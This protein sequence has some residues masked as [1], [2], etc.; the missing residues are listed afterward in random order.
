MFDPNVHEA[1]FAV[2]VSGENKP[3]TIAVIQKVGYSLHERTL[4]PAY[5]G[6]YTVWEDWILIVQPVE[7][8]NLYINKPSFCHSMKVW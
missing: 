6:V 3:N 8:D 4:R 5:V 2:P 7:A 1:M